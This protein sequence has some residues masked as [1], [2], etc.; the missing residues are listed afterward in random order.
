MTLNLD[1]SEDDLITYSEK[2]DSIIEWA[3][4]TRRIDFDTTFVE[5][6][7]HQIQDKDFISDRQKMSIDK[8]I[9][10]FDIG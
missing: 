5:N 7:L 2:C 6:I 9:A 3:N 8:I 4:S 10:T 1:L